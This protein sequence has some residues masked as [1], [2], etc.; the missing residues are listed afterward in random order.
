MPSGSPHRGA[1]ATAGR[2][3][4]AGEAPQTESVGD[5]AEGVHASFRPEGRHEARQTVP[6]F[7]GLA[8]QA[9]L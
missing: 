6:V 1:P 7:Y 9:L 8:P 4:G 3:A 5:S 2:A